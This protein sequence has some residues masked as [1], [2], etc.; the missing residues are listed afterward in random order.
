MVD[1]MEDKKGNILDIIED[2]SEATD[3]L[4]LE[5]TAITVAKDSV[6]SDIGITGVVGTLTASIK[7]SSNATYS[8][9]HATISGDYDSIIISADSDAATGNYT[10]T[11]TDS[12][13][14][15]VV[16]DVVVVAS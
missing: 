12:A 6:S 14:K 1:L 11:L 2:E 10:V 8:K 13:S 4:I 9:L 3:E 5:R 7:D 15:T 16:L